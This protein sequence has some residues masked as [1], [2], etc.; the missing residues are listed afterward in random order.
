MVFFFL[1]LPVAPRFIRGQKNWPEILHYS[2]A[3]PW[4]QSFQS[5]KKKYPPWK[6]QQT[7]PK[8]LGLLPQKETIVFQACFFQ[9]LGQFPFFQANTL[10]KQIKNCT[11]ASL[12]PKYEVW[13]RL[14]AHIIEN[15]GW[16]RELV[17]K[18]E[19]F[20]TRMC[21]QLFHV[22]MLNPDSK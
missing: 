22:F 7:P 10:K 15:L 2:G 8:K 11:S 5:W 21:C 19:H 14:N 3:F 16:H 13:N 18:W 9:V 17:H 6:W 12:T 20:T 1:K 4:S